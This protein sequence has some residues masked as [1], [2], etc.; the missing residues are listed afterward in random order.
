MRSVRGAGR[1]AVGGGGG[2]GVRRGWGLAGG[3]GGGGGGGG[4][5]GAWKSR[6][7]LRV[8]IVAQQV[9]DLTSSL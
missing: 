4:R 6:R 8:P 5:L 3:G 9:K 1:G 7:R 2:G